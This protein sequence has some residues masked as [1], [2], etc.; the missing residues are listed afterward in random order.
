MKQADDIE[1]L[2]NLDQDPRVMRYIT[3][4]ITTSREKLES[5]F[6]PR[7]IAFTQA[8]K[9]WGLWRVS[10]L[11]S[12]DAFG[13]VLIRPMDFFSDDLKQN[14][15]QW[16]NLEIGWRFNHQSWGK[17]YATEAAAHIIKQLSS[18]LQLQKFSATALSDNLGS[19]N[20]MQKI[21]MKPIKQYTHCDEQGEFAAIVYQKI[22]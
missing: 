3:N 8:N 12:G 9:G 15:P 4:G 1:F 13:W 10:D 22:L 20:I 2:F 17:G 14:P 19:I 7:V 6:V 16:Q 5:W 21:G 18:Q 11:N